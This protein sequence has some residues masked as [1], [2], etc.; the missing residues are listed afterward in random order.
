MSVFK[1][2]KKPKVTVVPQ[3]ETMWYD[4]NWIF[5]NGTWVENTKQI[6]PLLQMPAAKLTK[7]VFSFKVTNRITLSAE[8]KDNG[9]CRVIINNLQH[10]KSSYFLQQIEELMTK[11]SLY[12]W[13]G[14]RGVGDG[15]QYLGEHF[16][17]KTEFEDGTQINAE[18]FCLYPDGFMDVKDAI[19]ELFDS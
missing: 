18:G 3:N 4:D 17:I 16:F 1:I 9:K 8:V 6:L 12:R 11:H 15:H 7:F 2:F 13:A 19:Y 10:E 5:G 14:F